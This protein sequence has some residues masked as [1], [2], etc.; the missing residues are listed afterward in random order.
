[1]F[2]HKIDSMIDNFVKK[3]M[4]KEKEGGGMDKKKY[5]KSEEYKKLVEL[6]KIL[7]KKIDSII[8]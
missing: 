6:K 7:F 8:Y 3:E 4:D 1:M 2:I 5:K